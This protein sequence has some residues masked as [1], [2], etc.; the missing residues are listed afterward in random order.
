MIIMVKH[1]LLIL[2]AKKIN[3][4]VLL[5]LILN[6]W[7]NAGPQTLHHLQKNDSF[8]DNVLGSVLSR[9]I[10]L[11]GYIIRNWLM[12]LWMLASPKS[13]E[14]MSQML[15]KGYQ[16]AVEPWRANDQVWRM[17]ENRILLPWTRVDLLLY[18]GIKM[19]GWDPP[20]LWR[21]ICLFHLPI[22]MLFIQTHLHSNTHMFIFIFFIKFGKIPGN[23]FSTILLRYLSSTS[24]TFTLCVL[25][26]FWV[27]NKFLRLC[28]YFFSLF[29][30]FSLDLV[31]SIVLPFSSQILSSVWS[32]L[33][34]NTYSEFFI[35]FIVLFSS[36]ITFGLFLTF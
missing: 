29:S 36:R 23:I 7:L 9:E 6:T 8:P 33:P 1:H 26:L 22:L 10:E 28:S 2:K 35:S 25:I 32:N 27:P 31:I 30:F 16:T 19:I 20:I 24:G 34:L 21:L 4:H 17:S 13:L 3:H 5:I 11:I 15:S 18:F 12:L 14:L